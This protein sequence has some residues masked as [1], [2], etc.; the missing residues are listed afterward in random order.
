MRP[1]HVGEPILAELADSSTGVLA[2]MERESA[3]ETM[4]EMVR[5][6]LTELEER[7]MT[8]Q[9]GLNQVDFSWQGVNIDPTSIQ[10]RMLNSPD[11]VLM[12]N[13]SYPPNE[14]ALIWE[15]SSP[16]AQEERVRISYLLQGIGRDIVLRQRQ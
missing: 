15:V 6:S 2:Q 14:N 13:T 16:G 7:V 8:L 1:E 9:K 12:L 11:K 4:R 10:V 5:D 3:V